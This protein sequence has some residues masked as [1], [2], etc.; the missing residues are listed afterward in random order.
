MRTDGWR[1]GH[2]RR[3]GEDYVSK[4]PGDCQKLIA[5]YCTVTCVHR[6]AQ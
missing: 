3:C 4:P 6:M 5:G 2:M 1:W